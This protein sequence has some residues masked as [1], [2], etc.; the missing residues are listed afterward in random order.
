KVSR[1][2]FKV[3][4]T[5]QEISKIN[6]RKLKKLIYSSGHYKKKART[7]K[8]VSKEII[9]K[10]KGK[11]PDNETDLLAIKGIGRKTAN[12]VL[13]F[14][15]GKDVIPVDVHVHIIS[16]RLSWVKTKTPEQTEKALE[17]ILPKKYWREINGIFVLFGKE[18]C[19]TTSPKCSICPV[20]EYCPRIGV[21][22]SR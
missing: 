5:P 3:A 15:Y 2:L 12:I 7:L 9:R 17:V 21:T 18:I 8:H 19:I 22:R 13:N 10:H 6:L 14:A 4:S 16:N 1:Q 11:V 20:R